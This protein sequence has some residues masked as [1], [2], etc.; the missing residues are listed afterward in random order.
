[1][2][3]EDGLKAMFSTTDDYI[4]DNGFTNRVL[5]RLPPQRAKGAAR[6]AVILGFTVLACLVSL[7]VLPGGAALEAGLAELGQRMADLQSVWVV[8]VVLSAGLG[9]AGLLPALREL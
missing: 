4:E 7:F 8:A 5:A 9:V 2:H 1:M 6:A 3:D